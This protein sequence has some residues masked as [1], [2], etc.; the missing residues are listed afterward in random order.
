MF[1]ASKWYD[2]SDYLVSAYDLYLDANGKGLKF[3]NKG[4]KVHYTDYKNSSLY[5]AQD[6]LKISTLSY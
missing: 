2:I 5:A 4:L 3:P 6:E 1:F